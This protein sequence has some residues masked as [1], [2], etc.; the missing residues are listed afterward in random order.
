LLDASS[1]YVL[2]ERS[3]VD[4]S[5]GERSP[6]GV[7]GAPSSDGCDAGGA[8]FPRHAATTA[9]LAAAA[10]RRNQRRELFIA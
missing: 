10:A 4:F 8:L 7:I 5:K 1:I 9:L 2:V 6:Y 3:R